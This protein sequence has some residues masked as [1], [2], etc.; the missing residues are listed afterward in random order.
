MEYTLS[1]AR[2]VHVPKSDSTEEFLRARRNMS[3]YEWKQFKYICQR[4]HQW[5]IYFRSNFDWDWDTA[6]CLEY[7]F[8]LPEQVE[9]HPAATISLD[10]GK[11]DVWNVFTM[12]RLPKQMK[13]A[14]KS[15]TGETKY[16]TFVS[17]PSSEDV[18]STGEFQ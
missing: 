16:K 17:C 8:E 7:L 9:L 14:Y 1:Q 15:A 5:G 18:T 11:S 6:S 10:T 3:D 12:T 4:R 2:C 13:I